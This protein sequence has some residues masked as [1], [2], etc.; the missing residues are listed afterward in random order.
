MAKREGDSTTGETTPRTRKPR[1]PAAPKS[2]GKQL[3]DLIDQIDSA[4]PENRGKLLAAIR[5]QYPQGPND[6]GM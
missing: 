5:A 6:A 3:G 2:F 1:G 4:S